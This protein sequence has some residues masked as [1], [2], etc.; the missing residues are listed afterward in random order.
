M[1]DPTQ[2]ELAWYVLRQFGEENWP[3]PGSFYESLVETVAR[4]DPTNQARLAMA[5]PQL[6][7]LVRKAQNEFGG[8]IELRLMAMAP[9]PVSEQLAEEAKGEA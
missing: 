9:N 3:R 6:V 7:G 2:R 5:Y 1:S 8:M 4:A